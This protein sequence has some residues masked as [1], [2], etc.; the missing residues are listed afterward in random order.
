MPEI[1]GVWVLYAWDPRQGPTGVGMWS[2]QAR[3]WHLEDVLPDM[4]TWRGQGQQVRLD[5]VADTP[6]EAGPDDFKI[7]TRHEAAQA[8]M[9]QVF[10]ELDGKTIE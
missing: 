2:E 5:W 10:G 8:A 9:R 4:L 7:G 1:S 6:P 3:R